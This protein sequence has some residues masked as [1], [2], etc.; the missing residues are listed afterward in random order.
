MK[1]CE[2]SERMGLLFRGGSCTKGCTTKRYGH[3]K[4]DVKI[5]LVVPVTN[6]GTCQVVSFSSVQ[7]NHSE[8]SAVV[9]MKLQ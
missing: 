6:V 8:D 3:V 2:K 1:I 5:L 4:K 9:E 7:E